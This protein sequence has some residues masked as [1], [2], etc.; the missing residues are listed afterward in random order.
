MKLSRLALRPAPFLAA[1]LVAVTILPSG[2]AAQRTSTG[3]AVPAV[4]L[5]A[6]VK[7]IKAFKFGKFIFIDPGVYV[8]TFGSPLEFDVKRA[9]YAK[10]ITITQVIQPPGSQPSFRPLPGWAANGWLG[11]RRFLRVAIT[12]TKGKT[13]ADSVMTFCPDTFNPQRATPNSP[14]KDPFPF[15]CGGFFFG[16]ASA[17]TRGMVW[18]LQRGWGA[19]PFGGGFCCFGGSRFRLR[20]GTYKLTVKITLTWRLLLHIPA[21]A[22]TVSVKLRVVKPPVRCGVPSCARPARTRQAGPL[23]NLPRVPTLA[24]PP[25]SILPD[26]VPLPS[27]GISVRNQ[28][29]TTRHPAKA[30]LSFGATVWIGG[31]SRLDV[32]GFR[33]GLSPVMKAFQYFWRDGRIVGRARA[34][35]MGFDG[36]KGHQHWHFQQFAQYRLL[37]AARTVVLRSRK[38]GFCI[39]P[40]DAIDLLLPHAM[41]QPTSFGFGGACGSPT[42]LWVQ[43][44][45]PLG[46]GDTYFQ[47]VAGQAFDIT[48]LPNG[49]YYIEIIANPDRVLHESNYANDVSLRKVILGGTPGNRTVTV[50]AFHGIDPE[51]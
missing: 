5:I 41:W 47:F 33:T 34:G 16:G 2:L 25:A 50:P 27:H 24:N 22:G 23:P 13:V 17:F 39:A 45:L 7:T 9:S 40:T 43:E 19:D 1:G 10:P 37:N 14:A 49:T 4:K 29:A 26:L 12:N 38:V 36:K 11:L 51:H 21:R 42:A 48:N 44:A 6:T 32:E 46:W 18:G 31:H 8:A 15:G 3:H 20:P 28:Q 30:V 35:T